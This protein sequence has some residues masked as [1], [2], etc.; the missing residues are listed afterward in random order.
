MTTDSTTSPVRAVYVHVPFCIHRC[1]YC[2]FTVIAGRDD[3]I[4][5]YLNALEREL[6]GKLTHPL[7]VDTL[8]L[9]GGTPSYLSP[10]DMQQLFERL[11]RWFPLTAGGEFSMECNPD[12]LTS[13]R[14]AVMKGAGVN[15]VSL[16]VQS[17]HPEH[18]LTLERSHSAEGVEDVVTRLR[19]HGFTNISFD[20]IFGVP[21]Q[22]VSQWETTLR[23]AVA[24]QPN[25]ISTYGL[26]FEK[27]TPFWT[28]LQRNQI[29]PVAE[30]A[31]RDMYELAMSLLPEAGYPQYEL[32][33][34]AQPDYECRHNQVYWRA[35]PFY[36]IGPG[37]AEFLQTT[38][39]RNHRSVTV[40]IER[41]KQGASPVQEVD[42]LD[43]DLLAREAVMVGLRQTRGIPLAQFHER[44]GV[45]V[46]DLAPESYE[47]CLAKGWL[48]EVDQHV[49]LTFAGRFLA[50]TVMAEFF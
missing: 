42:E 3:L 50:D 31:E 36:G 22:S 13:D 35:E 49:R 33:N 47:S 45:T 7:P 27:G 4:G 26:T 21:Q 11:Q 14:M 2:D 8:F 30:E 23:A 12:G 32:S 24:L 40:W 17:L 44:Y 1:G 48:E 6:A 41:L 29:H 37:A 43:A 25:H 20:L 34:F 9:G 39:R 46:R 28:R 16:G 38:R 19:D 18:L 10:N 15:R 5:D